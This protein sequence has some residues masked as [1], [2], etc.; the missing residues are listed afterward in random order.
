MKNDDNNGHDKEITFE[1]RVK[2]F[3]TGHATCSISRWQSWNRSP[4]ITQTCPKSHKSSKIK[5]NHTNSHKIA[6]Y[7]EK[8]QKIAKYRKISRNIAKYRKISR[9]IAKYRQ[10]HIQ[11]TFTAWLIH[12]RH[13][14]RRLSVRIPPGT[15]YIYDY[16]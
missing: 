8:L 13:V 14:N 10:I 5:Q 15:K 6:K 12:I 11:K 9:N 3:F 2:V 16:L 7:R 4:K 1:S